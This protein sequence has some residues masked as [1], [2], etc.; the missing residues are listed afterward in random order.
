MPDIEVNKI[1][2]C[3]ALYPSLLA[4]I[5]KP[6]DPLYFVGE[7]KR[8]F[9]E[10]TLAVVGSRSMTMYG[11]WVVNNLVKQLA[12]AKVTI[13][14]GFMYGVDALAH[15]VALECGGRTIAV[16]AGGVDCIFPTNQES[17]YWEIVK[18]GLVVSEYYKTNFGGKWM[19]TKRNRIV[20]GLCKGVLVVEAAQKS[21][22]LITASFARH[23][24][25]KVYAVPGNINS[26]YSEGT[27]NLIKMGAE[28][29]SQPQDILKDF[30]ESL[31]NYRSFSVCALNKRLNIGSEDEVATKILAILQKGFSRADDISQRLN[32]EPKKVME[33]LTSLMLSGCVKE[34]AGEYYVV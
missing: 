26:L 14:S 2:I 19:F 6:P 24:N 4:G 16:M 30:F 10:K 31:D 3:D 25:R 9:F 20:A 1:N 32:L 13:V 7:F 28:L 21:G 18:N 29:V 15:K 27:N 8:E 17:L 33:V 12:E 22:A 34:R 5:D 11:E 23:Y